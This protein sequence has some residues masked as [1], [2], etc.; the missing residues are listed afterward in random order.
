MGWYIRLCRLARF[1]PL[2]KWRWLYVCITLELIQYFRFRRKLRYLEMIRPTQAFPALADGPFSDQCRA[3]SALQMENEPRPLETIC[4]NFSIDILD[5]DTK[6]KSMAR[7]AATTPTSTTSDDDDG[8]CHVIGGA[9]QHPT[10]LGAPIPALL[11]FYEGRRKKDLFGV[12]QPL[13]MIQTFL[14]L[15]AFWWRQ[16]VTAVLRTTRTMCGAAR[17]PS[18]FCV[19]GRREVPHCDRSSIGPLE[20]VLGRA[21]HC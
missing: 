16:S 2:C 6:K 15:D 12:P 7:D 4:D 14:T 3:F 17:P 9:H 11:S 1:L 21:A 19:F 18:E 8:P 20:P 13:Q 5:T 10:R